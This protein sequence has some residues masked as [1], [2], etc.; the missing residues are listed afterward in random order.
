[1]ITL[2]DAKA[3]LNITTTDDDALIQNKIDAASAWLSL[4]TGATYDDA[5]PAPAPV[6]EACRRLV[7]SF[8]ADR[9]AMTEL[10]PGIL[11]LIDPY[12]EWAF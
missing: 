9:E 10:P 7:A 11:S 3:H 8:Y 2:D 1:M 5:E 12:R 4:Y 6:Q